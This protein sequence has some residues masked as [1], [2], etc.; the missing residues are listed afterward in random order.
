MTVTS[1]GPVRAARLSRAP[2]KPVDA[3]IPPWPGEIV[4][5]RGVDLFVR[6]TPNRSGSGEPALYVH[7]LGGA[8]TNWTDLADLLADRLDGE[9]VDLPGFGRSGP[10]PRSGY[11]PLGHG[12][13]VVS[14]LE[15]RGRGPVHLFG[16]SLGGAVA[17]VVAAIRPDLVR[18]LTLVSPA[19]PALRPRR[20]SDVTLPL[21]LLPGLSRLVERRLAALPPQRRA[22]A[23]LEL[24]FADPSVVPDNRFAEAVEEVARRRDLPWAMEAFTASLR[25]LVLSYALVGERS[26]WRYAA[27]VRAPTLV[28]WGTEDRLVPVSIAPRV[29]RAIP[30]ARLLVLPDVG[31]VAQLERP[32]KVARAFLGML[33]DIGG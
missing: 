3:S 17:V 1:P 2:L 28:V 5:I 14:L 7:G 22:R 9:A 19:L 12:R 32:E 6:H 8:S 21:L 11:S 15:H 10:V 31:H 20:G 16:N 13:T 4:R 26:L 25:G 30:D 27:S 23:V 18:T 24:C 33:E 29:A